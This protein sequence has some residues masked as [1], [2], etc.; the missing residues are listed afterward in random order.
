MKIVLIEDQAMF[1]DLLKKICREHFHLT[2][3]GEAEDAAT[4]L[5]LCRRHKPAMVLLDLN[6]PDRDGFAVA[7]DLLLLDPD[8]L[9]LAVSSECD[10]YTLYRVLNSGMR[11]Y[12][13]KGRQSVEVLKEAIDE[14]L[15]GRIFFTEVVQQVRQRLR[16]EPNAFPKV[17]TEREQQLLTLLGGGMGDEEVGAALKL[18]RYTVRFH[19]HNIMNKL[20]LH[21]GSDLIRYAV[22]K[23]FAKLNSFRALPADSPSTRAPPPRT[24]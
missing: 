7:D 19:R 13:D 2:V 6:L 16:T 10:D 11:G 24:R 23:G 9:I 8:I 1:R 22:T 20:N 5:A 14:V 3:V 21:R 4:G 15:K 18:S 12:V 17:L